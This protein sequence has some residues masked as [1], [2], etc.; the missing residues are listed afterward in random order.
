MAA[1]CGGDD[2]EESEQAEP[3]AQELVEIDYATSFGLFGRDAYAFVAQEMGFFEE[4]GFDV[5]I[6]P[7]NG[8]LDN[9]KLIASGQ[10]DFAP[11]DFS[12]LVVARANENIPLKTVSFVHRETLSA[13]F[14]KESSGIR[15]PKDLEGKTIGDVSG[16]TIKIMFPL[17]AEKVGVDA[18]AVEFRP[19]NAPALPSLLASDAVDAVGQFV[20]GE[21]LF[22][23]AT[24][25]DVVVLPYADVLEDLPG[26]GIV[27]TDERIGSDPDEIARFVAALNRGLEFA[28]NNPQEAAEI[29]KRFQPEVDVEIAAQELELMRDFV[30]PEGGEPLGFLASDRVDGAIEIVQQA[31]DLEQEV[32]VDDVWV[33]RFVEES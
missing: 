23:K 9:A 30:L 8:S 6:V 19:A 21:P 5:S 4:A 18:S 27:T 32:A 11:V 1:G 17:Y 15:E 16:S 13:I 22:A 26:I 20:V 7:G 28:V 2:E 10:L 33:P 24:R 31:F 25:G 14:A 29:M 3:A 12:A